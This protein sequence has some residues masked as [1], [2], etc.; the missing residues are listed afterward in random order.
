M[1]V[2]GKYFGYLTEL[3]RLKRIAEIDDAAVD[4]AEAAVSEKV[5]KM[6]STMLM[7]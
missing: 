6:I 2:F 4:L 1:L 5:A 7:S 3:R